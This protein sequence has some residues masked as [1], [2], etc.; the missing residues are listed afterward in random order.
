AKNRIGGAPILRNCIRP[1]AEKL[2]INKRIG[3]HTFRHTYCTLLRSLGVE[4]KVMQELMRHSSLR[5][6]LDVYTQAVGP[7]KRAAQAAVL[8]LFFSPDYSESDFEIIGIA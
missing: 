2:G 4:F 3:W 1:T 6:T 7:A 8:S 5:S